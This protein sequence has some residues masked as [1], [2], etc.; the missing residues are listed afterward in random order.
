[1]RNK[2]IKYQVRPIN[3]FYQL[4]SYFGVYKYETGYYHQ[5]GYS[6]NQKDNNPDLIIVEKE[7]GSVITIPNN[8][9]NYK[10]I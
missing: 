8:K 9:K 10:L 7:D 1:M 3:W 6:G 2:K 5:H 4:I